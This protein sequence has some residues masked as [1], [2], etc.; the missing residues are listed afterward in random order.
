MPIKITCPHCKRAMLVD[1]RLAGKKGRCKACQ[2]ILTVPS[3]PTSHSKAS[4]DGKPEAPQKAKPASPSGHADVEAEAAALFSDETKP[5]ET[6][7]VK[8]IDLDCPF[9]EEKIHLPADLAGKRAPCPE[10]KHIIKVPELAKKDPKDWRKVETRGPTGARPADQPELEGVWGSTTA[11]GVGKEALEKAGVIAK[12]EKPRTRWQKVRVPVLVGSL[13]LVLVGAGVFAYSWWGRRTLERSVQEAVAFADSPEAKPEAK[14]ALF[15]AAGE[16]YLNSRKAHADPR[17]GSSELPAVAAKNSFGTAFNTLRSMSKSEE[18]DALLG[19]LALAQIELEGDKAE[20]DAGRRLAWDE[21]QKRLLATLGQI[22]DA[23]A[24]LQSLRI[25]AQRLRAS[26]KTSRV[27]PLT[28]QVFA[29]ADADKA[30]ALAFVGLEFYKADDRQAAEK[31]VDAAL[32][33]PPKDSKPLPL[34]AEVVALALILDKKTLPAPGDN[35]EDKANAHIGKVEALARLGKWDDARKQA[36]VADFGEVVQF[37]ARLAVAAAAVDA[38]VPNTDDIESAVKTAEGLANKEE[39]SWSMLR[40]TRLALRSSLPEDRVQALADKI[41]NPAL[42]GRAQLV[43]FR[44]RLDQSKQTV[45][46]SAADKIDAKT[47]ARS[48]AALALAR[49]NTRFDSNYA[50][51]VQT[52]QQPLKS[53]GSL[54]VALGMQDREK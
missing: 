14:A 54:G 43:I 36:S 51:V 35:A 26:G 37:R 31:A 17:T 47:L 2:Q 46:D 27:L 18:R 3:L 38:K 44:A 24:R 8:T 1:E 20:I 48:L 5:A 49:H 21:I 53:F 29:A 12:V 52:W 16:Y 22:N 40:L 19:D 50:G 9:C 32:Q 6:V 15:L 41:G 39:L 45:E 10:C 25:V 7:E 28:N 4:G 13:L 23:E 34:R 30:A 33:P 42:R 11:R